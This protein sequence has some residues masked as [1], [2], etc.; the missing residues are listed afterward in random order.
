MKLSRCLLTFPLVALLACS[1][2]DQPARAIAPDVP[3]VAPEAPPTPIKTE[4]PA[5][6]GAVAQDAPI[7]A[8]STWTTTVAIGHV[9]GSHAGT[10]GHLCA[11]TSYTVTEVLRG[12]TVPEAF[13]AHFG[14]DVF[15]RPLRHPGLLADR[16][17]RPQYLLTISAEWSPT[18]AEQPRCVGCS[19]QGLSRYL[20]LGETHG[21]GAPTVLEA[22]PIRDRDHYAEV[23]RRY[24]DERR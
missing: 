24:R 23:A 14:G 19:A 6:T 8:A 10:H 20:R 12:P 2:S 22:V 13:Q 4:E 7:A 5:P 15:S 1:D 18:A 21:A 3:P 17:E 9:T 16:H 11:V